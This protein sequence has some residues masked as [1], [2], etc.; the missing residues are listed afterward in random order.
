LGGYG[1]AWTLGTGHVLTVDNL[2]FLMKLL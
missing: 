1:N 2:T